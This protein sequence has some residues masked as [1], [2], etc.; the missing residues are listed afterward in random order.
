M[1]LM[2]VL[3]ILSSVKVVGEKLFIQ[4]TVRSVCNMSI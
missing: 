3:I 2:C 1:H 4:F